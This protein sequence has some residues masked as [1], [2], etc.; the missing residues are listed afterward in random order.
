MPMHVYLVDSW[1]R[2]RAVLC[3]LQEVVA[4]AE[5]ATSLGTDS[6]RIAAALDQARARDADLAASLGAAAS[7]P[8]FD[9]SAFQQLASRAA[10]LG[11]QVMNGQLS[12]N[13]LH[14]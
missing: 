12:C 9:S 5:A 6:A 2:S 7:A 11:L 1:S 10:A 14:A 13:G 3:V 8:D 4:A